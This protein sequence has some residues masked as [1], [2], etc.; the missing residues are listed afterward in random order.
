MRNLKIFGEHY[1]RRSPLGVDV[2]APIISKLVYIIE[3]KKAFREAS[4]KS[5]HELSNELLVHH[6]IRIYDYTTDIAEVLINV[7]LDSLNLLKSESIYLNIYLFWCSVG[8]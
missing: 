1:L 2:I 8:S 4:I 5:F 6:I 7:L 3:N